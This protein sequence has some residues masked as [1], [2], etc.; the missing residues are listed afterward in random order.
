M[1][2]DIKSSADRKRVGERVRTLR[3]QLGMTQLVMAKRLGISKSRLSHYENG[4]Y[5]LP[6]NVASDLSKLAKVSLDHLYRI[7]RKR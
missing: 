3:E 5:P 4:R 6:I 7:N 2:Y 1:N